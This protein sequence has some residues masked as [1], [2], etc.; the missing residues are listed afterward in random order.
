[1]K[2]VIFILLILSISTLT[3]S[4]NSNFRMVKPYKW[5]LGIYMN[6]VID[7][8]YGEKHLLNIE[9]SW[10]IPAYPSAINFDYYLMKG[11][12]LDFIGSVN[13]YKL[14]K[15][16]DKDTTISG[17]FFSFN[18]HFKYS[19]GFIMDQQWFD[20]FIFAGIGYTGREA[21]N[22]ESMFGASF[23]TG[24]NLMIGAGFGFQVRGSGNMGFSSKDSNYGQVHFG[25]IYKVAD[26]DK[27]QSNH[28]TKRKYQWGFKKPR[29]KKPR[30]GKM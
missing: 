6:G 17:Q 8:G 28:F 1:M 5:M 3:F 22:P 13:E 16:I 24:F 21:L 11:M 4:Q 25:L 15:S 30:S 10:N 7:D 2:K 19:L 20:P 29:Y 27:K 26:L 18:A 9:K 12:S 23:G 14:G